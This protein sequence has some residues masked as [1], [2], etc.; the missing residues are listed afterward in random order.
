VERWVP[1]AEHGATPFSEAFLDDYFAECD[2]HLRAIRGALL[3]LEAAL[4]ER[5]LDTIALEQIFR[6]CH[7]LKGLSGM[8]ELRE[9]EALAHELESYLRW[10]REGKLGLTADGVDALADGVSTLERVIVARR[11]QKGMP[12]IEEPLARIR[13]LADAAAT[14]ALSADAPAEEAGRPWRV[15]YV[16]TAVLLER[17]INVNTIR[18]RLQTLGTIVSAVPHV[19]PG[20]AIAFE[21]VV[22][23][24]GRLDSAA[25]Q[26]DG[27]TWQPV[28]DAP[29]APGVATEG[30]RIEAPSST[31][32]PTHFVRVDL[33]RLDDL[34]RMIG[35]LVVSRARLADSLE[36]VEPH[37]PA[38]AWRAVQEHQTALDR[39]VRDLRK[40]IM[41]VRLVPIGDVFDRMHFV[42]RDLAREY[43]KD[44]H[45]EL[46]G[47]STEIDKFLI[48]RL[49]DPLLHLVRN[50]VAHG[51]ETVEGRRA[52][53]KPR[54]GVIT[55][56]ASTVGDT[57]LIEVEDD[58]A[59]IDGPAVVARARAA[60]VPVPDGPLDAASLLDLICAAGL[61][62]R[63][64]ADRGSGRGMGMGAVRAVVQEVG[65]TLALETDPGHGTRFILQL[66][67]TLAIT[68]AIIANVGDRTFAVPQGSV[69]EVIEVDPAA[70]RELENNEIVPYRTGTLP[71]VRLSRVFGLRDAPRARLHVFVVGRGAAA[72]GIA[73]DRV[74][75]QREI[76]V[77]TFGDRL[78]KVNGVAGAT[79]LG[80]GRVVLILDIAS[81]VRERR[82][83]GGR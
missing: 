62:T 78:I 28:D 4:K 80:D 82:P 36:R 55:L 16:P 20:G 59:G 79:E 58:G 43:G 63:E 3:S 31:A 70:V 51:L 47:K 68:D 57:V 54:E 56:R 49:M 30:L 2:E 5:R 32:A 19:E 25:W 39:H 45:L 14:D 41:R 35:D 29:A 74:I 53:R 69:S 23:T 6:G 61:S 13:R 33:A 77:R 37:V 26:E 40:G 42:V 1:E 7:S 34:M 66:P 46:H 50:A 44:V 8:V 81:L 15:R 60:G 75:G 73:V 12:S 52:A 38:P 65:G 83:R 64:Q 10:L 27:V 17:G 76:V 48:E 9:A 18:E 22:E 21:F 67:L 72:V 24:R 71:L 11:E